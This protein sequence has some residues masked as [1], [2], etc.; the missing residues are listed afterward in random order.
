[1]FLDCPERV[2]WARNVAHLRKE[3]R[4]K[5]LQIYLFLSIP[6]SPPGDRPWEAHH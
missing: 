3:T 5:H 2:I 4:E 1:M 6:P